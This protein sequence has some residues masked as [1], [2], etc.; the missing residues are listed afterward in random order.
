MEGAEAAVPE[1]GGGG[2]SWGEKRGWQ[3][4]EG[5]G[6]L[7]GRGTRSWRGSIGLRRGGLRLS[8]WLGGRCKWRRG[9]ALG[10]R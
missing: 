6:G 10:R 5:K 8:L 1:I 2:F 3:R 4:G 7:G 9:S